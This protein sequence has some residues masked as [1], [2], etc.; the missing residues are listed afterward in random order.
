MLE[1]GYLLKDK[2][3]ILKEIS[4]NNLSTVYLAVDIRLNKQWAVKEIYKSSIKG[5]AFRQKLIARREILCTLSHPNLPRIIDVIDDE[6]S[7]IVILDHI[8]GKTLDKVLSESGTFSQE[9]AVCLAIQICDTLQYLHTR[10]EGLFCGNISPS[11]I[12]LKPDGNIVLADYF[13]TTEY[14][15][16]TKYDDDLLADITYLG[17]EGYLAPEQFGGMANTDARTDI[18]CLGAVLYSLVTGKKLNDPPYELRPIREF[19]INISPELKYVIQKCTQLSP[20]DRFQSASELMYALE[21]YECLEKC[22]RN[23]RRKIIEELLHPIKTFS[24]SKSMRKKTVDSIKDVRFSALAPKN[25][26][27]GEYSIVEIAMY[28]DEYKNIATQSKLRD[29]TDEIS[30]GYFEIVDKTEV[31]ICLSSPDIEISDNTE[32]LTWRGKYLN[33]QFAVYLPENYPKKQLLFNATVYFNNIIATKIKFVAKCSSIRE[34]K[35]KVFRDDVLSAFI[36][37]ASQDRNRVAL[38]IQ[39]MKKSRP[40]M[41]IFFDVDALRSG[42]NWEQTLMNEI[43]TRDILFLC[44]SQFAKESKWVDTE[45]RYALSTKGIDSIEPIPLEPPTVCPPPKELESKHFNDRELYYRTI[46]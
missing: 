25:I 21:G 8:H 28:E 6:K 37:Y 29:G 41:E 15:F 31:S 45:W 10:S 35:M 3:E 16:T 20:S 40:D 30:T 26:L 43:E 24:K 5:I 39:G 22:S 4:R 11:R 12:V 19:N 9:E 44:W 32:T 34:Q 7:Y 2:Y 14:D 38:I 13:F 46:Q 17:T 33:F 27:K 23:R 1:I 42:E 18:Y 36:S